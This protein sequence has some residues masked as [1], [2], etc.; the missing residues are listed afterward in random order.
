MILKLTEANCGKTTLVVNMARVNFMYAV[1]H[2][3]L[4]DCTKIVFDN[5][6]WCIVAET[7]SEIMEML[8]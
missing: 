5:E 7:L 6:N 4:K 3:G 1:E 2:D 8:K